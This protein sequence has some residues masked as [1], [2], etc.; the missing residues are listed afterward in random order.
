MSKNRDL[1]NYGDAALLDADI[2]GTPNTVVQR[3]NDGSINVTDV[4]ASGTITGTVS[5]SADSLT[6]ARTIALGGDV[7]GSA[8]FDGSANVTITATVADDSHNHVIANV[9]GLQ[10][11]LD[12]KVNTSQLATAATANSVVQRTSDGSLNAEGL[13]LG[14]T[15]VITSGISSL[16]AKSANDETT[17]LLNNFGVQGAVDGGS[18]L[19]MYNNAGTQTVSID[20]RLGS[21]RNTFLSAGNDMWFNTGGTERMRIDSSGNVG[22]GT[23][24]PNEKLHVLSTGK[25]AIRIDDTGTARFAQ[26]E[27]GTS[28]QEFSISSQ[29]NTPYPITFKLD[30]A[31][32]MRITGVG[33]VGIGT[34]SPNSKVEV[35]G[36]QLLVAG[37]AGTGQIGIQIKGFPLS[38]IPSAQVQGYIASGTSAIGA[39]GDL[40]IAPRTTVATSIRFITGT[41]PT[42]RVRVDGSGNVGIGTSSP[43]SKLHIESS[44]AGES[45]IFTNTNTDVNANN[46]FGLT[47]RESGVDQIYLRYRRDGTGV[48]ELIQRNNSSLV[49]GTDNTERMRIAASGN[50]G[51]GTSSPGANLQVAGNALFGGTLSSCSSPSIGLS[52]GS[53]AEFIFSSN[54]T[55]SIA[56]TGFIT[57]SAFRGNLGTAAGRR[58]FCAPYFFA[59]NNIFKGTTLINEGGFE[60]QITVSFVSNGVYKISVSN[61]SGSS[62]GGLCVGI[63]AVGGRI[64][65]YTSNTI[66]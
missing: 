11:A 64:L 29:A 1:G 60:S 21:T 37:L 42:E 43:D 59:T 15:G 18:L 4:N 49:F 12:D 30:N 57:V 22:I 56:I 55:N 40:L 10:G 58:A 38:E 35:I 27:F 6:T 36:D 14:E 24:S 39:N 66:V 61:T 9:D 25:S 31:E 45:L 52:S 26:L 46:K 34:S 47:I 20:A 5:G 23:S 19:R 63:S 16:T 32:R 48:A 65:S 54:A 51:I 41:T 2:A 33:N 53:T 3:T 17:F 28:S 50:V 7:S 13:N 44:V 8:S 62:Y